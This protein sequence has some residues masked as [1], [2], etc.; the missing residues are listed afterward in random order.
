MRKKL[1]HHPKGVCNET[2]DLKGAITD[3]YHATNPDGKVGVNKTI[4]SMSDWTSDM[5]IARSAA[6]DDP[7][8]YRGYHEKPTDIYAVYSA[9]DD[10]NLYLMAELPMIAVS[11]NPATGGDF[12]YS[13]DQFLPMGI[14]INTGKRKAGDGSMDDTNP[15]GVPWNKG[16]KVYSHSPK[17]SILW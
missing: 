16:E 1:H 15:G 6:N 12:D 11:E 2:G 14:A 17:A 9:W 5:L 10:T 3:A 8:A 4:T 7:R 13:N